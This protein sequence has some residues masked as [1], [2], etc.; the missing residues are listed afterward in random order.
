MASQGSKNS[1]GSNDSNKSVAQSQPLS[2]RAASFIE[3]KYYQ[4]HLFQKPNNHEIVLERNGYPEVAQDL[5]DVLSN[6]FP[7]STL[8]KIRE[9]VLTTY[10]MQFWLSVNVEEIENHGVCITGYTSHRYAN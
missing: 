10:L 4:I 5:I 8:T 7:N 6:H 9:D 2:I 1:Q 3:H